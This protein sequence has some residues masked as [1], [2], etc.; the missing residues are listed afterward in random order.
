MLH[1]Q[2]MCL[3][4]LIP[5]TSAAEEQVHNH[6]A[7]HEMPGGP[8]QTQQPARLVSIAGP[9]AIF[10]QKKWPLLAQKVRVSCLHLQ[11]S[12]PGKAEGG[13]SFTGAGGIPCG[14]G[15]GH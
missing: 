10:H 3:G 5:Q 8:L 14:C 15:G 1:A 13:S 2:G 6:A 9:L 11:K 4:A 7:R 12:L